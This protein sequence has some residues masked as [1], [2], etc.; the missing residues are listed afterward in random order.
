M[1]IKRRQFHKQQ[2]KEKRRSPYDY[3][4]YIRKDN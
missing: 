3:H 2:S 1:E 4:G